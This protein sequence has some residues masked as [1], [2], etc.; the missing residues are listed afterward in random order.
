MLMT[1]HLLR[2]VLGLDFTW[3]LLGADIDS[4]HFHIVRMKCAVKYTFYIA[5]ILCDGIVDVL[6]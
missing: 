1:F 6:I 2:S 5:D 3:G 4:K